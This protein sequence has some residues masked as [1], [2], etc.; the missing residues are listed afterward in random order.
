MSNT[1][2][3]KGKTWSS[4]LSCS[5]LLNSAATA[6]VLDCLLLST[7]CEYCAVDSKSRKPAWRKEITVNSH[8]TFGL[9]TVQSNDKSDLIV[10]SELGRTLS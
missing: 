8:C 1:E 4:E 10:H 6:R 3:Q 2:N 7:K 9:K 5:S